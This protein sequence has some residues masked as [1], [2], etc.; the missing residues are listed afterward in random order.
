MP[1]RVMI[2]LVLKERMTGNRSV[3]DFDEET[4]DV[5]AFVQARN[6]ELIAVA[7]S[8]EKAEEIM[9]T[10]PRSATT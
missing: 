1:W 3:V 6:A 4:Q 5:I 10:Y 9:R 2:Y 8:W 7:A